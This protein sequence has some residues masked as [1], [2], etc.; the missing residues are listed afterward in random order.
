VADVRV[1]EDFGLLSPPLREQ[2]EPLVVLV[3]RD[4][5][6]NRMTKG[7]QADEASLPA[8]LCH[9]R[10]Q[11][12]VP[13][14]LEKRQVEVRI[15]RKVLVRI[16]ARGRVADRARGAARCSSTDLPSSLSAAI[17]IA[18]PSSQRRT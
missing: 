9:Q 12:A 4:L 11:P 7:G 10:D 16:G 18:G 6:L 17:L 14:Q 15:D 8:Q 3:R 2:V 5:Q 13:C 1:Y